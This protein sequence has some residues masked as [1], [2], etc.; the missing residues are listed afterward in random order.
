MNDNRHSPSVAKL[1]VEEDALELVPGEEI[2]RPLAA[3]RNGHAPL[4]AAPDPPLAP[5]RP[6]S[7]RVELQRAMAALATDTVMLAA[8]AV[9][10]GLLAPAEARTVPAAAAA[11][12]AVV[13]VLLAPTR[14]Y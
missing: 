9:A 6:M 12:P 8:S 3:E 13:L 10:V 5:M 7:R 14:R 11:Y 1:P 2:G 4:A